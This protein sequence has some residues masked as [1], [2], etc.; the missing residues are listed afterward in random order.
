[1]ANTSFFNQRKRNF[2]WL[3]LIS[4]FLLFTAGLQV[5]LIQAQSNDFACSPLTNSPIRAIELTP[6]IQESPSTTIPRIFFSTVVTV[7]LDGGE[8]ICL[9]SSPDGRGELKVDDLI[10]LQ[11]SHSDGSQDGWTH[12]FYD[13]RTGGITTSSAQDV[14]R[15]FAVRQNSVLFFLSDLKPKFNSAEPVWLIVWQGPTLT[16]TA[17][18][19]V[20]Q[21][22]LT[23]NPTSSMITFTP[24][25]STTRIIV[26]PAITITPSVLP[27]ILAP[28]PTIPGGSGGSGDLSILALVV[29]VIVVISVL[30]AR[31]SQQ[32][33]QIATLVRQNSDLKQAQKEWGQKE[34]ELRSEIG[35]ARKEYAKPG[36]NDGELKDGL[37][38]LADGDDEG[39]LNCF[40]KHISGASAD[41]FVPTYQAF[42][43]LLEKQPDTGSEKKKIYEWVCKPDLPEGMLKSMARVLKERWATKVHRVVE[44]ELFGLVEMGCPLEFF[45]VLSIHDEVEAIPKGKQELR[46][47]ESRSQKIYLRAREGA[48]DRKP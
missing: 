15:V 42:K 2:A 21:T 32:S 7:T 40:S 8:R 34:K 33:R 43:R 1:M 10:T 29:L 14:S 24:V 48:K 16:P 3:S 4:L 35:K 9:S 28:T 17:T 25:P 47:V 22:T 23:A 20:P 46:W 11:V 37:K 45:Q 30:V 19:L 12:N 39:A 38:A 44:E 26:N 31:M 36:D 13:T 41:V 18:I 6:R 5:P 27:T